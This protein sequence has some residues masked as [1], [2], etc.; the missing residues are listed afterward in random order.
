M[1]SE[2]MRTVGFIAGFFATVVACR[3]LGGDEELGGLI[4]VGMRLW[5]RLDDL[6]RNI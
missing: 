1:N 2:H 3:L 5:W 4:Y 6:E